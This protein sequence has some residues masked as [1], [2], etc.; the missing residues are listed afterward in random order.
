MRT[1]PTQ[2]TLKLLRDQGFH[3]AVVEKWNPHAHVRQDLFGWI[4]IV[5]VHPMHKGVLGVQTTTG[6]H[7][8]ERIEKAR[9]NPALIAWCLAGGT[10]AVHGWRKLKGRWEVRQI[11]VTTVDLCAGVVPWPM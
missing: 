4:D 6:D 7:V 3:A 9:G 10:L 5:G 1:S 8:G 2:R 11:P